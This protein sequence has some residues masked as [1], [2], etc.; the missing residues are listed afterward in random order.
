MQD[1]FE[2]NS[3]YRV[4][5]SRLLVN[6]AFVTIGNFTCSPF[7]GTFGQ[8][9]VPF[10]VY[11]SVMVS[12]P[13]TKVLTRT[14]ARSILIG[15]QQQSK[16]ALYGAAYIFRGDSHTGSVPKV[17]NGGLNLGFKFDGGF[18]H[19]NIGGGVIANIADSGGMQL[20]VDF[21]NYEQIQHKV[22][23]YNVH[24]VLSFGE[25][26]DL[27]GE[28]VTAAKRFSPLDMSYENKGA[29]PSAYDLEGSYSFKVYDKPSSIGLGYSKS[30]QA[31]AMGIPLSRASI[32]LNTSLFR[33]TLQS[34]EFRRDRQYAASD[35][36]SGAGNTPS[37]AESGKSD[38]A[39]TAQFDYYF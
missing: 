33:N 11:S 35:V 23:G 4:G 10:G 19:G 12:E 14:K 25:H 6:K 22:P 1:V 26:I 36:A 7:Y 32:V 29:S 24:T 3:N 38:N 34:L 13:L 8:F 30:S 39:V 9:Y 2:S 17:D 20:G 5:N 18:L 16:N 37:P 15:L 31:L 28:Y 27:I 21:Q